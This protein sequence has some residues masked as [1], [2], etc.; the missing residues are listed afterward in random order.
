M[1]W[2]NHFSELKIPFYLYNLNNNDSIVCSSSINRKKSFIVVHGVMYLVKV[3]ANGEMLTLGIFN[4]G[5]IISITDPNKSCYYS[6][7]AL[8]ETFI[9]SFTWED[10]I[11][12]STKKKCSLKE[13]ACSLK[14]ALHQYEQ[15]N[16]I[17]AH[18]CTRHRIIQLILFLAREYGQISSDK[19]KIPFYMS[20]NTIG[21][22]I[23]S[24]T[25][26]VSHIISNLLDMGILEYTSQKHLYL[27]DPFKL[28]C[29]K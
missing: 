13:I 14:S 19:I 11:Y 5:D 27:K 23:G 6:I 8:R 2:L 20:Q 12:L 1:K 10:L 29:I 21:T 3:F 15:M 4:K 26:N 24:N 9:L 7:I 25:S 22:V 17:L 16:T 28:S 18:K